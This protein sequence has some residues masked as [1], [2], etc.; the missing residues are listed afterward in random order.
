MF[1]TVMMLRSVLDLA[2]QFYDQTD[3]CVSSM[4]TLNQYCRCS[5]IAKRK[6]GDR[7]PAII[8]TAFG[9]NTQ[10]SCSQYTTLSKEKHHLTT[11]NLSA[12]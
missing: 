12:N 6:K 10:T 5:F 3:G 7:M 2:T 8:I 9:D 11:C 1:G 4:L